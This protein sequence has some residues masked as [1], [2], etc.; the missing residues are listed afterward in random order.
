[1]KFELKIMIEIPKGIE[2]EPQIKPISTFFAKWMLK[3][4]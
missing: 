3:S 1:M 2:N 4:R